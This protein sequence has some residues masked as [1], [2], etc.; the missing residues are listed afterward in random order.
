MASTTCANGL[1]NQAPLLVQSHAHPTSTR[2]AVFQQSP[3]LPLSSEDLIQMERKYG[4]HDYH[5]IP[6]VFAKAKGAEVWDP[7]GRKYLD[8]LSGYSALNQG[9]TNKKVIDALIQQA[10]LLTLS[11]RAFH[12][13]KFSAFAKTL[14]SMFGYEMMLPMNTGAEGVETAIKLARKW[15][16]EKKGIP[17]DEAIII[18]CCGCFHGRTM[19]AI[20]MSCDNKA[21]RGFWPILGGLA[22]VGFGDANALSTFLEENGEKVAGFLLEPIQGEAGVILPPDG[23]LKTVRELCT[24]HNVLMIADEIQTGIGRTGRLLACDWES[25]R[26]DVVILGKALGAGVMPV[27]AV[28]ADADIML[29]IRPGEHGSTFGGNPLASAVALAA[30]EVVEEQNLCERADKLGVEFRKQLQAVQNAYPNLVKEVRGRGLLNAVELLPKGLGNVSAYELC[31]SLKNRGI[32]AKA[33]HANTIRLS[34]PLIITQEQL[35]QASKALEDVFKFELDDMKL[36]AKDGIPETGPEVCDRC[37][38]L[39]AVAA[40]D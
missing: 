22:K 25:V 20:S 32:L 27:S 29:C 7:E 4:A 36:H 24:K 31:I 19:A 11:S 40:C 17:K 6:V 15:G 3:P 9:H 18:S 38:S 13:D 1:R 37:G 23:Y 10:Q 5:P 16:Y 28:L 12:N 26:P 14:T 35:A 8:F 21:T 2:H 30:L 39:K 33:T 34:P